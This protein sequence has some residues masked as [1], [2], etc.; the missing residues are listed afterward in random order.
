MEPNVV[1]CIS[2]RKVDL[3]INIPT[4]AGTHALTDGYT[5]RRLAIDHRIPLITNLQLAQMLLHCL[6][7]LNAEKI[8]ITSWREFLIK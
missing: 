6:S 1:G 8:P 3:I 2:S 5:I 4:G 7:E